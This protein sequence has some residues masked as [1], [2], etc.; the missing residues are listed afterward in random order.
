MNQNEKWIFNLLIAH[1]SL[2]CTKIIHTNAIPRNVTPGLSEA[3]KKKREKLYIWSRLHSGRNVPTL[4]MR[5]VV[6]VGGFNWNETYQLS[7]CQT[8]MTSTF[9]VSSHRNTTPSGL[10]GRMHLLHWH[11]VEKGSG[12]GTIISTFSFRCTTPITLTVLPSFM[13]L[14]TNRENSGNYEW[15]SDK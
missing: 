12:G 2:H 7:E 5:N 10:A 14:I 13:Y 3:G 9:D 4:L 11:P 8:G 15:D 1:F 6:F